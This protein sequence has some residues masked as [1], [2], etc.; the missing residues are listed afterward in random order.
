MAK[1]ECVDIEQGD[2]VTGAGVND[3]VGAHLRGGRLHGGKVVQR[4]YT[5][6]ID[7]I[8]TTG[9]NRKVFDAVVAVAIVKDE[10]IIAIA[11]DQGVIASG[12]S[13]SIVATL[14]IKRILAAISGYIVYVLRPLNVFNI[15]DRF[16][17]AVAIVGDGS[18]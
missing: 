2:G 13:Q 15:D 12:A 18:G 8:L 14:T 17:I 4:R 5:A 1:I 9:A 10:Q 7:H 16:A 3:R 6:E 11:A